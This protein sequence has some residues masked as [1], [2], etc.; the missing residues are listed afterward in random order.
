MTGRLYPGI[1]AI[2]LFSAACATEEPV[3][4]P[5]TTSTTT[6]ATTAVPSTTTEPTSTTEETTTTGKAP[7]AEVDLINPMAGTL[8]GIPIGAG[9]VDPMIASLEETFGSVERDTGWGPNECAGG[10]TTRSLIWDSL[11]VYLEEADG[12]QVLLGYEFEVDATTDTSPEVI[13]L[14]EG[15]VLGMT[16]GEAADLY[17]D[18][19]YGHES[20]EL[21]GIMFESAHTLAVIA[22][23]SPDRSTPITEVWVGSI[24]TC[25]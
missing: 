22:Q 18:D 8:A 21:D 3:A 12:A 7:A 4:S 15:I 11:A 23:A 10:A 19:A 24:P 5:S 2:A 17:P 1:L 20:L 16:Y 9:P 25:S 6:T 14:P 13:E